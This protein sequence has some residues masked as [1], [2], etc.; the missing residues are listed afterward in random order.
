MLPSQL[1]TDENI[2]KVVENVTFQIG[3]KIDFMAFSIHFNLKDECARMLE[4]PLRRDCRHFSIRFI[5]IYT[6]FQ[7]NYSG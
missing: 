4:M 3:N 2:G 7:W 1:K 5:F 6:R